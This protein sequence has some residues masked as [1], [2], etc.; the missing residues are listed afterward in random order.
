[1]LASRIFDLTGQVALVTGASSGLGARFAKVLAENGAKTI[2]VARR[3]DRLDALV[4]QITAAGGQALA[5]VAD[6][7]DHA[8]MALAY[9]A[10][11]EAFGPV[12]IAVNNAGIARQ[13]HVLDQTEKDWREVMS[14]NLDAVYANAQMAAQHMTAAK[15]PGSIINIA[16]I[17][18]YNVSKSLSAYAVA[19]AGVVQLT[20]AMA[21]ELAP[22]NIRVNCLAPGYFVTEINHDFL[23]SEKGQAMASQAPMGRFGDEGDLDGALLLLAS[24][25]GAFMTGASLV[26]DGGQLLGI[27][28]G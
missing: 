6:V 14:V 28:G 2:C 15:Q 9:D 23:T 3:R 12:S 21:L 18:G 10:G 19:K 8:A 20:K 1:M 4:A 7:T 24:R 16:S 27:R 5:V 25:A 22:Q 26:V 13:S 11:L 17:L